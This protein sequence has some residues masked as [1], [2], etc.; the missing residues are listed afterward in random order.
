MAPINT[1]FILLI[2]IIAEFA[3]LTVTS[4]P[5]KEVAV[6]VFPDG[7]YWIGFRV[8]WLQT[9]YWLK[10]GPLMVR[11]NDKVYTT[12]DG[13][14]TLKPGSFNEFADIYDGPFRRY[15][16]TWITADNAV[17]ISTYIEV[18]YRFPD[19]P[20]PH[21]Y[22]YGSPNQRILFSLSLDSGLNNTQGSSDEILASFPSFIP[23][24]SQNTR[25]WMTY[26][27]GSESNL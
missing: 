4:H 15:S 1:I 20:H 11:N 25:G 7:S 9:E 3:Q 18:H 27:G 10:S 8:N 16:W 2:L 5:Q 13:S 14:L 6:E 12:E 19:H 22:A 24:D 21:W 23:T 17:E 26:S